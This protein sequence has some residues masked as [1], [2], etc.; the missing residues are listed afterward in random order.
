MATAKEELYMKKFSE[1]QERCEKLEASNTALA[2]ENET[3]R[4]QLAQPRESPISEKRL[5]DAV[6]KAIDVEVETIERAR[7]QMKSTATQFLTLNE[8]M[9]GFARMRGLSRT[10]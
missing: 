7:R 1:V 8:Y 5:V 10:R 4:M 9:Q 6:Q 3:L 2:K